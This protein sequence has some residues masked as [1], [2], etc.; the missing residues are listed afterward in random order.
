[1]QLDSLTLMV[2]NALGAAVAGCLLFGA[3]WLQFRNMPALLWWATSN[4]IAAISVTLVITGIASAL[5]L[6]IAIGVGLTVVSHAL[7]WA[8]VRTFQHRRAPA[9]I[10]VAGLVGWLPFGFL[11]IQDGHRWMTF[12]S[13]ALA[14]AYLLAATW[15]LWKGRAER[16]NARWPLAALLTLHACIFL[17]GSAELYFGTFVVGQPPTLKSVFGIILFENVLYAMG[18]AIFMILLCKERVEA[19][20]INAS[21]T[22]ALTGA[23]TRGAIFEKMERL[24][25]RCRQNDAPLSL[26]MFDLD[27]FKSIN[28]TH[29]HQVGDGVLRAFADTTRDVLRPKDLF[30]RYGGEEFIVA[31][32]GATIE[33]AYAIAQR[34][35]V[36]FAENYR[37]REGRAL[38][39]T[40]SAGIAA[41]AGADTLE[42]AINAADEALYT[43]K[44]AGRNRVESATADTPPPD[45]N[46]TVVRVA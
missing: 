4:F 9:Y 37:F 27:H 12:V 43:A 6:A 44:K 34:V 7:V 31:L 41:V 42:N 23:S 20:F 38:N 36:T 8:G 15:E 29:G 18:T 28:D 16:L 45:G 13:F 25:N 11:P 30:G 21:K 39:A 5:P 14:S 22:D 10:I 33:T 17:G 26:I 1:M 19:Q 3:W 40:V 35:R 46:T 2:P 24:L 32:P